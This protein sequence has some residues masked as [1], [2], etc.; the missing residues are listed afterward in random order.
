M[1]K[2][3]YLTQAKVPSWHPYTDISRVEKRSEG[4]QETKKMKMT[5]TLGMKKKR[6]DLIKRQEKMT[7][8]PLRTAASELADNSQH[9]TETKVVEL[10]KPYSSTVYIFN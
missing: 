4:E 5:T 6:N 3:L 1:K 9:T 8:T 7:N 2:S 10:N